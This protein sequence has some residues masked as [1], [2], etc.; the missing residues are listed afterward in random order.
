M[1]PDQWESLKQNA[2]DEQYVPAQVCFEG[3]Y[4]GPVGLRFKGYYGSLFGCFDEQGNQTCPRL[5]MKVKFDEYDED[6]RFFGLKRL[7]FNAYRHDD[8]RIKEKLV[9]DLYRGV[10]VV[11]P[12]A[13]WAVLSVNG[14][15]QGLYG[16]VEQVDGRF[17]SDRWPN[18]PDGNLYKEVWPSQND[19]ELVKAALATNEETGDVAPFLAF[20]QAMTTASDADSTAR[21]AEFTNVDYLVRYMA[22]DDAVA[23][24]DGVTYFWTEGVERDNH[25]F[26]IYEEGPSAYTLIPWDVEASFWINPDHAAPHWTTLPEDCSLTYPY[27]EGQASAP[28]CDPVFRALHSELPAWR[29]ASRQLLDGPFALDVMLA[30]I[31]HHAG[32]IADEAHA[33][34]TPIM[35]T[36][37]DD[38]IVSLPQTVVDLR[39]RLEALIAE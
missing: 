32:F 9:Y 34:P 11:A 26:Y 19:P 18:T 8:S 6:Q 16:M 4:L 25:N 12:R 31:D 23:N 30:T 35:Y 38:A 20:A 17:T 24:Y 3:E 14:E 21:L 36:T 15:S 13:A 33:D 1:P 27:W 7:N 22:V 29:E 28:G 5:S 39:A 2:R 37:F 10:G